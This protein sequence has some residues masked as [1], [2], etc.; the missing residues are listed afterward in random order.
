MSDWKLL[1]T[2]RVRE[3]EMASEDS[4]GQNG[5]FVFPWRG[6]SYR[7]V[8]SD[9]EGWKHVSI[10][11][12]GG[13][14]CP[15]WEIMCEMKDLFFEPEDCVV[16]Y[17]PAKSNYVNFHPFCLHLWMPIDGTVLPKP[18]RFMVGPLLVQK[19]RKAPSR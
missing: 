4:Y 3:G 16:Q 18:P 13:A 10:S 14:T 2:F 6:A 12:V 7:A 8:C 11:R 5:A 9:G 1:N 17:H 15:S 19:A